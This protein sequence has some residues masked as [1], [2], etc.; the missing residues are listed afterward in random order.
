MRLPGSKKGSGP[1]KDKKGFLDRLGVHVEKVPTPAQERNIDAEDKIKKAWV[2][3]RARIDAGI[4]N[5]YRKGEWDQLEE[6]VERPAL[7]ALKQ[8]L[9][10]LRSDNIYWEQPDRKTATEPH[11]TVMEVKNDVEGRPSEFTIRERFLDF[12]VLSRVENRS[13]SPLAR[14]EGTE[15]V[16]EAV[17]SVREGSK[18]KLRSVRQVSGA[19]LG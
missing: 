17:V 15:R 14:S 5:Y 7:D 9:H 10:A 1:S 13:L 11:L 12:S 6:F 4:N 16:I 2:Y 3:L 18:F 19:T 8:E